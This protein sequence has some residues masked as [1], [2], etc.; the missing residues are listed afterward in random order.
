MALHDL[1]AEGNYSAAYQAMLGMAQNPAAQVEF[2]EMEKLATGLI[3]VRLPM[4]KSQSSALLRVWRPRSG[5]RYHKEFAVWLFRKNRISKRQL[6][7][8]ADF[9]SKEGLFS[10]QE[11]S[12][13]LP[14]LQREEIYY[15]IFQVRDETPE[16]LQRGLSVALEIVLNH[17]GMVENIMSS[18][19][20]VVFRPTEN[21]SE[22]A[23]A[24]L[25]SGLGS[26]IRAVYGHGEYLRG[27]FGSQKH[28]SYGTIFPNFHI[29]LQLLFQLDFGSSKNV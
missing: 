23:M 5:D 18:V 19:V 11:N 15:I 2:A 4:N 8:F 13:E 20:S 6:R 22:S 9:V 27:V 28:F 3:Q 25:L 10:I 21:Q 24:A 17:R 16:L 12:K 26:N 14:A 29:I 7:V 1:M